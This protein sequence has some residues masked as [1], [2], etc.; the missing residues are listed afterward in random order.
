LG[1]PIKKAMISQNRR[2]L[3]PFRTHLNLKNQIILE[4]RR[5]MNAVKSN[6][7]MKQF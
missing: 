3:I 6:M 7:K 1:T 2:T 4:K 5:K